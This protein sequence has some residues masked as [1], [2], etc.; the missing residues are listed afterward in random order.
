MKK[1]HEVPTTKSKINRVSTVNIFNPIILPESESNLRIA[2]TRPPTIIIRIEP[3]GD[4]N[5]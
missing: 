5:T 2:L 1:I 4:S 3:I